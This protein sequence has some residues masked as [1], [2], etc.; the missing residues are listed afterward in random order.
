MKP[1][2]FEYLAPDTLEEALELLAEHGSEAKILW[3][4]PHP[5]HELSRL[6]TR[7]VDRYQPH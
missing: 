1:A 6:A 7:D 4:K 2:P 3:P 5:V